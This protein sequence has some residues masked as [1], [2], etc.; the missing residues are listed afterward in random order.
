MQHLSEVENEINGIYL[1]ALEMFGRVGGWTV[2]N[3]GITTNPETALGLADIARFRAS[4]V[5]FLERTH[6]HLIRMRN[7]FFNWRNHREAILNGLPM[8]PAA[9]GDL[10]ST[11]QQYVDCHGHI[12]RIWRIL[13]NLNQD[14]SN[15]ENLYPNG[16][17]FAVFRQVFL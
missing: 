7:E 16:M 4:F 13:S 8:W 3:F 17:L 11:Y 6:N 14:M 5:P 9:D 2:N 15:A 1:L 10:V 12:M